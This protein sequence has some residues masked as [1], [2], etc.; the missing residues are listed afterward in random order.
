MN[1]NSDFALLDV[2]RGR[3]QLQRVLRQGKKV[4]VVIHAEVD[5]P[6]SVDDGESVEFQ[7]NVEKVEVVEEGVVK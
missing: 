5:R 2:K 1:I 7:L 6:W 3:V 4:K